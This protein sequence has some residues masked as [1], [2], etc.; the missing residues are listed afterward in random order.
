MNL[1]LV[2]HAEAVAVGGS[3]LRDADRSLS[4]RGEEDSALMGRSL[5]RLDP[6]VDIV[7]TSPLVRAKQTGEIMGEE[8]SDHALFHISEHLAPGFSHT[9]LLEE[10]IDLSGGGSIVAVGHQPDISMFISYLIADKTH[11]AVAMEAGAIAFVRVQNI[12]GRV[13]SQLRWLL[14]PGAVKS[15]QPQL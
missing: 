11:A 6:N 4:L 9:A 13:E 15:L 7:I 2:R 3:I 1:Y 10:L 14:T 8:L 5:A 12:A